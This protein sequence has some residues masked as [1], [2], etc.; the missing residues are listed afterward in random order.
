VKP[1]YHT[2]SSDKAFRPS[3]QGGRG[4]HGR[5]AKTMIQLENAETDLLGRIP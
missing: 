2:I 4:A 1:S 5:Y 3:E